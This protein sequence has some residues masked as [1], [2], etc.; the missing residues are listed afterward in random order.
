V[1]FTAWEQARNAL[2]EL[3]N[4][5]PASGGGQLPQSPVLAKLCEQ[6]RA[7]EE[8]C[9]PLYEELTKIAEQAADARQ[10][11]ELAARVARVIEQRNRSGT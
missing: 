8:L 1:A 6:I 3:R 7:Q 5:L 2:T 10:D 4:Q 11:D 9:K